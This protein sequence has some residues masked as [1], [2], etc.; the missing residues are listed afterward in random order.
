M[1][2]YNVVLADDHLMFRE[3]MK[4]IIKEIGYLKIIGEASDGHELLSLMKKLSPHMVILDISMPN[5]RG[6][7]ATREIKT[8]HHEIKVVIL[9]M[10]NN[11]DYLRH[12]IAAGAE[13]YVLKQ[14]AGTEL[15]SAIETVRGG[16]VYISPIFSVG[17]IDVFVKKCRGNEMLPFESLTTR[18]REVIKLIAEGQTNKEIAELLFIS[19]R[20]VEKHRAKIMGKLNLN[21]TADLIKYAIRKKYTSLES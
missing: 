5:I 16:G 14:D 15:L 20:T 1:D 11:M 8:I 2:F 9:T 19:T 12:A 18:Q 10:H 4:K 13:G 17:L 21:A 7:E 3:G 6:I